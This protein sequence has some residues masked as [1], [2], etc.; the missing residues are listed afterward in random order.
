MTA[1]EEV[2]VPSEFIG[3]GITF[4]EHVTRCIWNHEA[5]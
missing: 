4:Q 3:T 5:A 1:L 2:I